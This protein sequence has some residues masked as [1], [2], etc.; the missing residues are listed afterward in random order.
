VLRQRPNACCATLHTR[1]GPPS[2][3][4]TVSTHTAP[5]MR[6]PRTSGKRRLYESYPM[7]YRSL[8]TV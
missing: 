5:S 4:H 3:V 7:A 1:S 8:C 2:V 6:I